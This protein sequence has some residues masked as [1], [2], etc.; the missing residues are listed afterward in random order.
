MRRR[1]R[2]NLRRPNEMERAAAA[3]ASNLF[4]QGIERGK[5]V[6]KK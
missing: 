5:K 4:E 1:R 3:G 6:P 2:R